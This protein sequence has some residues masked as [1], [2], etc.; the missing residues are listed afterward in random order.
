VTFCPQLVHIAAS[1]G[2][3]VSVG[4]LPYSLRQAT[5]VQ[6]YV[7]KDLVVEAAEWLRGKNTDQWA[8]PW[9]SA[10]GRDK[11]IE[12][13][14]RA[15][16]SWI[17]WDGDVGVGTITLDVKFPVDAAKN[18][19][20]PAHRLEEVALYVHRVVVRRCYSGNRIGAGL[21]DWASGKAESLIGKPLLR[22]DV[23]TNNKDLHGYYESKGF[24]PCGVR[25]EA[26]L[27]DYPARALFERRTSPNGLSTAYL[28]REGED[29]LA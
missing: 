1:W 16:R 29:L 20:W 10:I 18:P 24:T 23:W 4:S 17:A 15:G 26:E 2:E 6:A 7:I 9:P 21:L 5:P 25:A 8:T 27:P 13:D 19:V 3:Y 11:R 28:F 22:I 14:V 12:D